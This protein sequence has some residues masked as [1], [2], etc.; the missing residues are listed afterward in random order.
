[1]HLHSKIWLVKSYSKSL[2]RADRLA[3]YM[4]SM[5]RGMVD[6]FFGIQAS[7]LKIFKDV[8][9]QDSQDCERD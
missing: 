3:N 5:G 9:Q 8:K 7:R 6:N 2:E 4:M 1:M